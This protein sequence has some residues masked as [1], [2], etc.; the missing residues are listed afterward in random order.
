MTKQSQF[1]TS[2]WTGDK[3][4]TQLI[5]DKWKWKWEWEWDANGIE[6]SEVVRQELDTKIHVH[7]IHTIY[8]FFRLISFTNHKHV[9]DSRLDHNANNVYQYSNLYQIICNISTQKNKKKK[10]CARRR[11]HKKI[12]YLL[13]WIWFEL[14]WDGLESS[15]FS[16]FSFAYKSTINFKIDHHELFSSS[17][18][19]SNLL[20][21]Y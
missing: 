13:D 6:W 4:Q 5:M 11:S 1:Y 21:F 10:R 15:S 12:H 8:M 20:S 3:I 14:S 7:L 2:K 9:L 18:F 16:S 19:H 17:P